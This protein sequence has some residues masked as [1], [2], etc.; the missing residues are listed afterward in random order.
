MYLSTRKDNCQT[1]HILGSLLLVGDIHHL[2]LDGVKWWLPFH[3][4]VKAKTVYTSLNC[5]AQM[6]PLRMYSRQQRD[7]CSVGG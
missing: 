1:I 2:A 7:E 5:I 4:C 6:I 3:I